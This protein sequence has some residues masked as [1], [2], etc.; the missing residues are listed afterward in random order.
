[1]SSCPIDFSKASIKKPWTGIWERMRGEMV[2]EPIW[3]VGC[4]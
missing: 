4:F 3:D 2:P 1:M